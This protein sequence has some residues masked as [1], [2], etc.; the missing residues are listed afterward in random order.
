MN[1]LSVSINHRTAPVELRE[2]LHLG[3]EEIR[4][5]LTDMKGCLFTQG[6]IISTCNRT[7]LYGLTVSESMGFRDVQKFLMERKPVKGIGESNFQN[8]F[9]CGAVRHLFR[10][11][12]GIDSLLVGDNQIF[13]Q[14]KDAFRISEDAGMAG[15]MMKRLFD[16]ALKT[17]KRVKTE[18]SVGDGAITVSY[19]AVQ[20]TEKIFSN[21]ARKSALVIGAGETGTIAA[22]HLKEKGLKSITI[23]NRTQSKAAALAESLGC[24]CLEFEKIAGELH[25]FDIIISATSAPSVI[26]SE[27]VVRAAM[28]KRGSD[29]TCIMD[30]AIPRDVDSR[31]KDI[32]G[33]YYH[34][35]DSL[36]IIVDQNLKKRE[37][38]I[39]VVENIILEELGEFFTWHNAL[40]SA[41]TIKQLREHFERI[42]LEELEKNKNKF[43]SEDYEKL[44]LLTKKII[45]KLLHQPT[46]EIKKFSENGR[47]SADAEQKLDII[48]TLFNLE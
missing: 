12:S 23:A 30:I 36:K 2:S 34:D 15:F 41:P 22:R 16:S 38:E 27:D 29:S 19:A 25:R 13:G 6:F 11:I 45:N 5:M 39:P 24:S 18:T 8:F 1:L 47:N 32:E 3:Q 42:R 26:L 7:E 31:V 48:R 35:V 28:K 9:S 21:L 20:L 37:L 43:S 17:G 10:V 33:V 14:V 40:E 4:A 46:M 44:E